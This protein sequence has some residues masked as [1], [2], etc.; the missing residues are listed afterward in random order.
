MTASTKIDDILK[1]LDEINVENASTVYAPSLKKAIKIKP[2]SGKHQ[3]AIVNA[4]S[5]SPIFINE[6]NIVFNSI[7]KEII[8][9]SIDVDALTI[10]DKNC[11]A[12]QL[13]VLNGSDKIV[14]DDEIFSV[15]ELIDS[16]QNIYIPEDTTITFEPYE[17]TLTIPTCKTEN[18]FD[19][20]LN[21]K[22]KT[23]SLN[24]EAAHR[25]LFGEIM[26][27]NILQHISRI[28]IND[29]EIDFSPLSADDRIKIGQKL[30]S[31]LIEKLIQTIDEH[32]GIIMEK[33]NHLLIEEREIPINIGPK[34]FF[35]NQE[36]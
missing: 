21:A 6:F 33:T 23:L 26:S 32:F 12:I 36:K 35:D 27:S 25:A 30:P 8:V 34:L 4:Y 22:I 18:L 28:K 19:R 31:L 9:D 14:I 24:D 3:T 20:R 1:I 17:V 15:K 10:I 2:F 5:V 16:Y 29:R 11:I 7:L 13:K